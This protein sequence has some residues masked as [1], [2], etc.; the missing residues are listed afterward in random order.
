MRTFSLLLLVAFAALAECGE[1]NHIKRD[2][3]ELLARSKRR[4]VLSTIEIVEEDNGPFPKQ[5]SQ[6]FNDKTHDEGQKYRISGMGVTEPPLGVFSINE[7]TGVVYAHTSVDREEFNLFKIKFDILSK[8]TDTAIDKE[9]AFNVEIKDINDNAPKFQHSRMKASIKESTQDAYLPVQ[10]LVTDID[11]RNTSN[12][13]VTIRVLSQKPDSP[14]ISLIQIDNRM[15]QLTVEGCFDYDKVNKYEVIVQAKDHGTPS[16]SSTA[17]VTLNIVD[18]N[19][20]QPT[21]KEKEYYGQVEESIT[22]DNVLRI[23]VDDKD[24]PKTPGWRA[25]YY[26]IKGN[27]GENY[28]I[29][30]DP[31]TNEGILSVIKGKDFE[32]TTNTTLLIRVENE[33]EMFYCKNKAAGGTDKPPP[34]NEVSVTMKVIDVNDPPYYAKTEFDVFQ[35]EEE[36]PG[37]VLFTPV[38]K[39]PDSDESKIRHV[40][41]EDPADWVKIDAKTGKITTTKKMDRESPHVDNYIYKIVVGAIDNGEPPAT[42]TAT[43]MVHLH[44]INDNIPTLVSKGIILCGN[45]NNKVMVPAKDADGHPFGGPFSFQLGGDDKTLKQRWKLDPA[46]G[47]ECGLVMLKELAYGNYSVPL[48]ISDHQGTSGSDTVEV[49]VCDCGGGDVCRSK[50]LPSSRLGPAGIGLLFLGLLLFLLLLLIFLCQCGEKEFKH[51]PMVQDEGNQTLIK[52]NQEGGGSECK[53]EPTLLLTPTTS[54]TVTDGIKMGTMKTSQAAPVMAQDVDAYNSSVFNTMNSNMNS[55][56][57]Q[58]HDTVRSQGAGQAMYSAWNTNRSSAYHGGSS[59]YNH[60]YSLRSSHNISDHIDR[61]LYVIEGT[62][63]DHPM[64]LPYE[65]AYEGQGSKCQSLDKLSLSNLGDDMMFLNDLGP[66]F[67]TLGTI[68]QQT[69]TEKNIQL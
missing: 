39:D 20:H 47:D 53:T 23:G 61:R 62:H 66:K 46:F 55:M 4:W 37:N 59:K 43:V 16:L 63:V 54:M 65:Y 15:A 48:T 1:G 9:L 33:E 32:M 51:M 5:I 3:R 45:K 36:E 2:K 31:E 50:D 57:M 34:P 17:V 6:M 25:K 8:K 68:C 67:K 12:S 30:T 41:L 22:K 49:M 69:V 42:G 26:I 38:V 11:Q 56:G 44:D 10:L 27:E 40:L 64:Y 7:N 60:S 14:K 18:T 21:F 35:R 29:E 28:K 19:S 52:Y 13:K 24:T 58:R